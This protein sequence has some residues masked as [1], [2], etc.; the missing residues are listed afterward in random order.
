[1]DIKSAQLPTGLKLAALFFASIGLFSIQRLDL[2]FVALIAILLLF[3]LSGLQFNDFLRQSKTIF[4]IV[5]ILFCFQIF[6]T[7]WHT[8]LVV[9]LRFC[10]LFL[11]ASLFTLTTATSKMM[12]SL[13]RFFIFLKPLGINPAKVSL[14]LSLTLRFIPMFAQILNEVR[15]AQKA[16]GLGNNIV[17]IINPLI[18][19]ALKIQDDV[20]SAIKARGYDWREGD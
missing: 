4:W 1:M 2:M 14:L 3:K 19:R 6:F 15:E 5:A 10:A 9:S 11:V 7:S 12:D 13:E 20:A 18:I 17:A 16:R 8:A